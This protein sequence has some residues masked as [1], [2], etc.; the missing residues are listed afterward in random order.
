M[1][2]AAREESALGVPLGQWRGAM[3]LPFS[4]M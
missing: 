2:G 4:G 1:A 3:A